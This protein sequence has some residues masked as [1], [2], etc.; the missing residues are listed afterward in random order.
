MSQELSG[1]TVFDTSVLLELAAG[2]P[3]AEELKESIMEGRVV[4]FTGELNISELDYIICRRKGRKEADKSVGLLRR[5]SQFRI[6]P[7][8]EFLEAAARIKCERSISLVD[9]VMVAMGEEL[10]VPVLFATREKE[11]DKEMRK[12]PFR[13]ELRFLVR[14]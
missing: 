3:A 13:T 14:G 7:A 6:V 8:S 12:T 4:P 2:S 1:N 9:S 10:G 5:A 11:I